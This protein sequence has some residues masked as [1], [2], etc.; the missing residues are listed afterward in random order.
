MYRMRLRVGNSES[1]KSAKLG[2]RRYWSVGAGEGAEEVE[3]GGLRIEGAGV[4]E[5]R[6]RT[7]KEEREKPFYFSRV[8]GVEREVGIV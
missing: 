1:R 5:V 7:G 2:W 3:F 8:G 6:G 4:G